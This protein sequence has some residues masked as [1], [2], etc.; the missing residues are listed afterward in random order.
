VLV[1]DAAF[2]I[3]SPGPAS[4]HKKHSPEIRMKKI[5][6]FAFLCC[7]ALIGLLPKEGGRIRQASLPN[8]VA[9]AVSADSNFVSKDPGPLARIGPEELTAG[10]KLL[11]DLCSGC[12]STRLVF[13]SMLLATE[14]DSLVSAMFSKNSSQLSAIQHRQLVNYLQS[15]LPRN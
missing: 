11:G 15:R 2:R 1:P 10:E 13:K 12:H 9:E 4:L 7:L 14:V 5:S 6:L 8:F 3:L